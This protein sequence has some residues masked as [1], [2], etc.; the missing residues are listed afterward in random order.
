MVKVC[1]HAQIG[2][3][4]L[5]ITL[6]LTLLILAVRVWAGWA[7]RSLSL[8]VDALHTLVD[9]F[10]TLL[11]LCTVT[12][13]KQTG[14]REVVGHRGGQTLLVLCMTALTGFLGF[15]LLG[16]ALYQLYVL[17][18]APS[19]LA[20]VRID[21]PL[22]LLLAAVTLVQACFVLFQRYEARVLGVLA[23]RHHANYI[24]QGL[25]LSGLVLVGLAGSSRGMPWLDATLAVVLLLLL[26]PSI[27]Q[28]L[29]W[30]VPSMIHSIAIAPES[31]KQIALQIEGV[32]D[33]QKILSWGVLG[34]HLFIQMS[35]HLHPE[36]VS[37]APTIV[38]RLENRLRDRYGSV[39][40]KI[41]I[42]HSKKS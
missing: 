38:E 34:R 31:L 36:F 2:Y 16:I 40:A 20:G 41:D 5:L 23:L 10:S 27:W 33:C 37:L 1:S 4:I 7:T 12:S 6:W 24:L 17:T 8:L 29:N 32:S 28:M 18:Y 3:R 9:S 39:Q 30:Q 35:L 21:F 42:K 14:G 13:L 25:W 22:L 26:I 15:S 19:L 11:S